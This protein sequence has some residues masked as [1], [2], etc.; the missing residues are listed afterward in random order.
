M[1]A[2]QVQ[3]T[4]VRNQYFRELCKWADETCDLLSQA[5]HLC[6]LDPAKCH[7][8]SFFDRRHAV[9]TRLSGLIDRGRWFFPNERADERGSHKEAAFQGYR[10]KVIHSLVHIW[11]DGW[12]TARLPNKEL[13][14]GMEAKKRVFVSE[15][16]RVLNPRDRDD[17]FNRIL[18][19]QKPCLPGARRCFPSFRPVVLKRISAGAVVYM[20]GPG[21]RPA[22]DGR[23]YN[24]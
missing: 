1:L 4:G 12:T 18:A 5:L 10:H 15:V 7:G 24:G 13:R 23:L 22:Q 16:Q 20:E 11:S 2:N 8:P 19:R 21:K 3:G 14:R 17:E 6:D 9:L